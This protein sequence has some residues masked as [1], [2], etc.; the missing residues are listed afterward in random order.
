MHTH[1]MLF[2]AMLI[3]HKKEKAGLFDETGYNVEIFIF[4]LRY[5]DIGFTCIRLKISTLLVK[6][7]LVGTYGKLIA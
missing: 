7:I 6:V 3:I 2:L 4:L 1:L 5:T